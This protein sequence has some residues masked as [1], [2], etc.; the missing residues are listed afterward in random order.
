MA[1]PR[2]WI[3]RSEEI[4][5]VLRA[6]QFPSFDRP[7][8]EELFQLQRRAAITL[9][10]QV[11]VTST[12]GIPSF[13]DR[14]QLISWVERI[15]NL[16]GAA[17]ERSRALNEEVSRSMREIQAVRAALQNQ[18]RA[19]VR[20]PLV[21]QVLQSSVTSLPSSIHIRPGHIMIDVS[22]E[23]QGNMVESACQQLFS[24]AMAIANDEPTFQRI[25]AP[26]RP[27]LNLVE[28]L[29]EQ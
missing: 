19:P 21:D 27:L 6:M 22:T 4:L 16:E 7:A 29:V 15:V 1:T 10:S 13:V 12:P 25:L 3:S 23:N 11:G 24:L 18:G 8:I 28:E 2:I 26:A 20:F 5:S 17:V 14:S 9:M